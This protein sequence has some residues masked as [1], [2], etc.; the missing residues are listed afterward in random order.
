MP[1]ETPGGRGTMNW[2]G[3]EGGWRDFTD[4]ERVLQSRMVGIDDGDAD[5]LQKRLR[6]QQAQRDLEALLQTT[7]PSTE[8]AYRLELIFSS[9]GLDDLSPL[10][11]ALDLARRAHRNG[12]PEAGLLV[13]Q[14]ADRLLYS[15]HKPQRYGTVR[16]TIAGEARLPALDPSVTDEERAELGLPPATQL[17]QEVEQTIRDSARH[18][19]ERGLPDGANL[20]RAYRPLRPAELAEVLGERSEAVWRDGDDTR[21][22]HCVAPHFPPT[23]LREPLRA[24]LAPGPLRRVAPHPRQQRCSLRPL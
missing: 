8:E 11:L 19:A 10:R 6:R 7:E 23:G 2:I 24:G 14:C 9:A 18:V 4:V 13:A 17:R 5:R 12:H 16:P 3:V 1:L 22:G 15:E 21:P 20:R